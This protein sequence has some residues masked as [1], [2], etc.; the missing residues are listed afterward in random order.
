MATA[1]NSLDTPDLTVQ[2]IA[3]LG[4]VRQSDT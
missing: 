3:G 1:I 4:E 2:E